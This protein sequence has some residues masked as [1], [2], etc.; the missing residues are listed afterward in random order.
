MRTQERATEAAGHPTP[1]LTSTP[2]AIGG[3][4]TAHTPALASLPWLR[5]ATAVAVVALWLADLAAPRLPRLLFAAAVAAPSAWLAAIGHTGPNFLFMHLLVAWVV[6][7]GDRAE[8]GAALALA[9]ATLGVGML[10]EAVATGRLA[11]TAWV[12]WIAGLLAIWA[13]AR[14]LVDQQRLLA[15][16]RT[17][18][19]R[20]ARQAAENERLRAEAEGRARE[21]AALYAQAQKA[22][23]LEERQRLA[24]DLHDSATQSLYGARLHAEAALRLLASGD[25]AAAADSLREVKALTRDALAEMRLLIHE[26]RPPV[27]EEHGL[28]AA[29]RQ[30][31]DAVEG[32]AGLVTDLAVEPDAAARLPVALEQDLYRVA[33]EALNNALRHGKPGRIAVRLGQA[34]GR[35]T[36]EIADDGAGFDAA[37]CAGGGLGLRGM[38]ERVAGLGGTLDVASAPGRGTRIRAEVPR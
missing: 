24:R 28:A 21:L 37:A 15:A 34:P 36:L 16:L 29:L 12:S 35:V 6:L 2:G 25:S 22:A 1:G 30:R 32:R 10:G 4:G 7:T 31:L 20:L 27:L 33:Q 9:L 8:A 38:R 13:L 17:A 26:L 11:V 14:V 5:T 18:R 19:D 3:R 23:A